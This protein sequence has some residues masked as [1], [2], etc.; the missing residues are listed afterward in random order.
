[1][2]SLPLQKELNNKR[3]VYMEKI[4]NFFKQIL[5]KISA[6]KKGFSLIELLVVVAII[7]VLAAVAIPAYNGYRADAFRNTVRSTLNQINKAFNA[8]LA[9]E[10]IVTCASANLVGTTLTACGTAN[11]AVVNGINGT[12]REQAGAEIVCN[13]NAVAPDNVCFIVTATGAVGG[14]GTGCIEFDANGRVINQTTEDAQIDS[15]TTDSACG[16]GVCTPGA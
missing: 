10:N 15:V 2:A 6:P 13:V 7:G 8:C 11:T 4:K 1:M 3:E 16:S 5:K 14:D 12:L 9:A